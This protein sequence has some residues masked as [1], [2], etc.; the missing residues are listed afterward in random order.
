MSKSV[1]LAGALILPPVLGVSDT[2]VKALVFWMVSTVIVTIYSVSMKLIRHHLSGHR[3][4]VASV[5]LAATWISCGD[6]AIQVLVLEMSAGLSAYLLLLGVQCVLLEQGGFF[7]PGQGKLR[8][9]LFVVFSLLLWA[10]TL[11][12]IL[13]DSHFATFA[14]WGFILLGL[15]LAG[16]QAWAHRSK[17]H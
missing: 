6:L 11:S 2:L 15:L 12:R 16:W 9:R 14:P 7:Q 10:M 8:F 17:P 4:G 3:L 1:W 13:I 5:L